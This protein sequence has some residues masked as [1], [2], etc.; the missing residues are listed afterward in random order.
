MVVQS[1]DISRHRAARRFAPGRHKGDCIVQ[2]HIPA[3]T[4]MPNLETFIKGARCDAQERDPVM[5][6]GIHIRLDLEHKSCKR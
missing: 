6:G 1:D 4:H 3:W 2:L 5:V